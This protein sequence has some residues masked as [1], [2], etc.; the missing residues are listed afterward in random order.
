MYDVVVVGAGPSG[1][2]LAARAAGAG[3]RTLVLEEHDEIGA[4]VHCTGIVGQEMLRRYEIPDR[5][6]AGE[7]QP[8]RV[9][10]PG[11]RTYGLP[12]VRAWLLHRRDL[13]LHLAAQAAAAGA[14][15]ALGQRVEAVHA[16]GHHVEVRTAGAAWKGRVAVMATGAMT[17]LPYT[18]GLLPPPRFY[19]TAQ[20]HAQ[21][22]GLD[23][24]ELYL[25]DR[26]APGSFAY[27]VSA[28]GGSARLGVI[29]RSTPAHG[30]KRL[31]DELSA[32]GRLAGVAEPPKGRRIPMGLSP[33][34]VHGRILSV[35]DAAGQAKTTTGGGIYYGMLCA[36]LL[37]DVLQEA[38]VQGD[39]RTQRL[40]RYDRAWKAGFREELRAGLRVRQM[41]EQ[42]RDEE[43]EELAVLLERPDVQRL[44]VERG[45]FDR[46]RPLLAG[47][48]NLPA[49]RAAALGL[50]HRRLS[51]AP[52][53]RSLLAAVGRTRNTRRELAI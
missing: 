11:R 31:L 49:V 43:L 36:D 25:G 1:S 45:D 48:T 37:A 16:C 8:F 3:L 18:S 44:I 17:N 23:G 14:E 51:G 24:V 33:R 28:C 41:F 40:A 9:V 7:V 30:L 21:V 32:G 29:A 15:I 47:L 20:V 13:D 35:G 22:A 53:F 34:T 46:H 5:L 27:A 42:V 50:A 6:V 12:G 19:R 52:L 2:R 26:M 10:S 39:F 38:R 4:P